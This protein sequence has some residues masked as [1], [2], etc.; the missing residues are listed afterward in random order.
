MTAPHPGAVQ[1]QKVDPEHRKGL[2]AV[3]T[4]EF[5]KGVIAVLAAIGLLVLIH[6][7]PWDVA[8]RTLQFL[9]ID[10]DWRFAQAILDFADRIT[11]RTIKTAVVVAIAYSVLRFVEAYGL[12]RTRVWAEWLAL[13]SGAIYLPFEIYEMVRKP[14][15]LHIGIFAVN[16]GILA[17]IAYLRSYGRR[18]SSR[19][20]RATSG[21]MKRT[22]DSR[23]PAGEPDRACQ[24]AE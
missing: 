7:D 16:L 18:A 2:R 5:F 8:A 1:N 15:A 13:V 24:P 3:A 6:K 19:D 4:L 21:R 11:E 20:P 9:G 17:Y 22:G 23:P 14:S 12:W 10:L